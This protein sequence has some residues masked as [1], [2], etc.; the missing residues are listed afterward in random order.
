MWGVVWA[1]WGITDEASRPPPKLPYCA[2]LL[3][4]SH[5]AAFF[6]L[7]SERC[8]SFLMMSRYWDALKPGFCSF[9]PAILCKAKGSTTLGVSPPYFGIGGPK[10]LA[11]VW[12]DIRVF[13]RHTSTGGSSAREGLRGPPARTHTTRKNIPPHNIHTPPYHRHPPLTR[14]SPARGAGCC[15]QE[16]RNAPGPRKS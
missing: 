13:K 4:L 9:T 10:I 6:G 8:H 15:R 12:C 5:D 1:P 14:H 7:S 2:S 16:T 11:C 3:Q